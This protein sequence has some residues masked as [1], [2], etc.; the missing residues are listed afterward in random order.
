MKIFQ[1]MIY[2]SVAL[3]G[4]VVAGCTANIHDNTVTTPDAAVN[5]QT[6]ADMNNVVPEQIIP[7]VV[8][9]QKVYLVDPATSP[10]ADHV[11]DAGHLRIYLDDVNTPPIMITANSYIDIKI[12]PQTLA[13]NHKL[14]CRVHHHDGTPTDTK[15]EVNFTVK[16]MVGVPEAVVTT[17]DDAHSDA[18]PQLG[19]RPDANGLIPVQDSGL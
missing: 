14:I 12:P 1:L 16:I 18:S 13:G 7:L 8:T 9:V 11:A 5:L 10:P 3:L 4:L 6:A 15:V 19:W 17:P 2:G